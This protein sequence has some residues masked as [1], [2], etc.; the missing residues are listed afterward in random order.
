MFVIAAIGIV[1]V[2]IGTS[3]VVNVTETRSAASD[4][5]H[6]H[7]RGA[8]TPDHVSVRGHW[9]QLW[10]RIAAVVGTETGREEMETPSHVKE[11][12]SATGTEIARGGAGAGREGG[13][14][15]EGRAQREVK[16]VQVV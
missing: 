11:A 14:G 13:T 6:A 2:E 16:R 5:D 8:D 10:M 1:S 7:G 4:G 9:G 15:S 12:E 3:E